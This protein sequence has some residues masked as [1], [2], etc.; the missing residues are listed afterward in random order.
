MLESHSLA[1][2]VA[3]GLPG[4]DVQA[5]Q[6]GVAR[7][8]LSHWIHHVRRWCLHLLLHLCV[9]G[10]DLP[11]RSCVGHVWVAF[12]Q[13]RPDLRKERL[14]TSELHFCTLV[15]VM[16]AQF[17]QRILDVLWAF[18]AT[19]HV[20]VQ[21]IERLGCI[22]ERLDAGGEEP[23][24]T[25]PAEAVPTCQTSKSCRKALAFSQT[26][27]LSKHTLLHLTQQVVGELGSVRLVL[28]SDERGRFG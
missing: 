2:G 8:K 13:T 6:L 17:L 16:L 9:R 19:C 24:R 27:S 10:R 21:D 15:I 3:F 22:G 4:H 28:G 5:H 20:I 18:A 25:V 7:W 14:L 26:I 12:V 11:L 23:A 1:L